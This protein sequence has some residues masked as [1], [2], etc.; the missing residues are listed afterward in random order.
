[1]VHTS[2]PLKY[3][4][5]QLV[6][7]KSCLFS[8]C[9]VGC[10]RSC[11]TVQHCP[12]GV[13]SCYGNEFINLTFCW[14]RQVV[15]VR[16][17]LAAI[18]LPDGLTPITAEPKFIDFALAL[19]WDDLLKRETVLIF[20]LFPPYPSIHPWSLLFISFCNKSAP[21]ISANYRLKI[22]EVS[23]WAEQ[24]SKAYKQQILDRRIRGCSSFP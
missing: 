9:S 2:I 1:M 5:P 22:R 10:S 12:G 11:E 15:S 8:P 7:K 23:Q 14:Q 18:S 13:L 4:L 20:L 3:N 6:G 24:K 21:L 17:W 16:A 19:P